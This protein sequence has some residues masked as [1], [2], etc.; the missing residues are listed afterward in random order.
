MS[1]RGALYAAGAAM[2]YGSSYV[3]TAIALRTFTPLGVAAWRGVLG[4]LALLAILALPPFAGA[5]SSVLRGTAIGRLAALGLLGGAVFMLAM[6]AAVALVGATITAFGAGLYAVIAALLAIPI[7]GER[8]DLRTFAALLVALL[9]TLLLSGL[10]PSP[11]T[12]AGIAIALLAAAAFGLFL[13]LSRRWSGRHRLAGPMVGL[14]TQLTSA[15]VAFVGAAAL[16]Q[17]LLD[18]PIRPDAALA[19]AWLAIG[20]SAVASV[21][22]VEGMARLEAR[23]ASAFL[24]LNPP[25]AA[26]LSLAL[27]GQGL[28]AVQA[29]GAIA[30][31]C[32][33]G[34]AS[35]RPVG[36]DPARGA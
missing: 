26:V 27:L 10:A 29:L 28:S 7:L 24:L 14:A 4:T 33:I 17:P 18:G 6:N 9:G 32:A 25:T 5:R 3:A 20:P 15:V 23:H 22:V 8:I 19:M 16:A 2:L 30:I 21:L 12:V 34:L 13:V 31:L 1:G 36:R 35:L 11:T